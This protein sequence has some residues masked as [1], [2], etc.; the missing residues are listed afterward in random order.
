KPDKAMGDPVMWEKAE[1]ALRGALEETG[2]DYR[3]NPGD[4][5]FYGPK[6]DFHLEDCIG[7]SWQCG[8]I[9]LDFQMPEKFDMTY[10]GP[11]GRQ[12]RPVMLHRTVLGSLE[13]FLGILIEHYAGAFPFWLA[14][15]QIKVIPVSQE[16]GDYVNAVADRISA[17]GYRVEI[18]SRDEKLGKKIRTAQMEKIPFMIVCGD[19]EVEGETLSVR[20]RSDGDLGSMTLKSLVEMLRRQA[21]PSAT[22]PSAGACEGESSVV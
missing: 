9:Q 15:V 17:M 12:H 21:R 22:R 13:R 18:D 10:V 3:V 11:D 14:P 20:D 5:A 16:H 19:R 1:E 2:A 8:T 7:R 4:G 6:I